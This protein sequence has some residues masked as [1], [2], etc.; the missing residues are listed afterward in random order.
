MSELFFTPEFTARFVWDGRDL[1]VGSVYPESRQKI[2]DALQRMSHE[3]IRNRFM[4]GKKGFSESELNRLTI[5]DGVDHYALGMEESLNEQRG[6][7]VARVFRSEENPKLAE[8]GIILVDDYQ[9]M[10]LGTFFSKLLILAAWERGIEELSYSYLP[11]NLGI[12]KL[13]RSIHPPQMVTQ[14]GDTARMILNL[15]ELSL[16]K[17]K[18]ELT[19][20]LPEIGSFRLK[21]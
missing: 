9:K 18:D 13:V 4:G 12:V 19:R 20:V 1:K 11:Q 16:V 21:I 2:S 17:I 15:R 10:G 5:L 3:T 7:G 14:S 8:V 6:V